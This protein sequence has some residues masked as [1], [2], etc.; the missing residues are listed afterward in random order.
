ML[1]TTS[2]ENQIDIEGTSL[3]VAL[4][5]THRVGIDLAGFIQIDL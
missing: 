3:R 1:L 4:S 2:T 5:L